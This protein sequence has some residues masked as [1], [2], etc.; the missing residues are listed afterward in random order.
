MV[1]VSPMS[2]V[3]EPVAPAVASAPEIIQT[4]MSAI[5]L[6][7]RCRRQYM[8]QE[9][10][11]WQP[12]T[13]SRAMVL[14]TGYHAALASGYRGVQQYD[15]W[16]R[17]DANNGT[18]NADDR[19][20]EF[21]KHALKEARDVSRDRDGKLL[22][23]NDEDHDLLEDMVSYW[24]EQMGRKDLDAIEEIVSVEEPAY[25]QVGQYLIR[26]TLDLSA[27][28]TE[29]PESLVIEDH[30]TGD[31]DNTKEFL[32]LDTQTR[33]YYVAARGKYGKVLA[34]NHTF[35]D[36]EVPPG[37]GHR[38]LTT[39]T[40]KE[41]SAATLKG[42]QDPN[43]YVQ[44]TFTPL[45]DRQLDAFTNEIVDL[46]QEIEHAK[47]SGRWTRTKIKVGPFACAHCPFF[48]PCQA[49]LDGKEV[50]EGA[51]AMMYILKDSPEWHDIEAGKTALEL[52]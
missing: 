45:S 8:Y 28:Y 15:A 2:D 25:I 33:F 27:R 48:N 14:G 41:R 1:E 31:P 43:R 34:F 35:V 11:G 16:Y 50:G 40:G 44:R 46:I 32:G 4:S 49:E 23:L 52:K 18:W 12:R 39:P 13:A 30:K 24:F 17:D 26:N 10:R 6:F 51:A 47:E 21:L 22:G 9:V 29:Y 42:M 36:R 7:E 19:A 38:P 5:N 20:A 37:F 3:V